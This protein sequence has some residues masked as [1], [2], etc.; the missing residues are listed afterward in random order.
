MRRPSGAATSPI[1]ASSATTGSAKTAAVVAA[2]LAVKP[3]ATRWPG[4]PAR[5][6]MPYCTAPEAA[7]PPGMMLPAAFAAS[8]EV[9]T[10]NQL[11]VPTAIRCNVHSAT[12]A[13]AS[14]NTASP[15]QAG[16]IPRSCG[17][18]EKTSRICGRRR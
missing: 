7:P 14:K 15:S 12:N 2:A 6:S 9:P 8:C 4:T 5:T 11:R 16:L 13:I 18:D 3:D 1:P 17:Q 10:A